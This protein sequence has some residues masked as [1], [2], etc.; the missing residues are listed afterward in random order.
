MND[1]EI[2]AISDRL[3]KKVSLLRGS[4]Y[5]Y[6]YENKGREIIQQFSKKGIHRPRHATFLLR[7]Q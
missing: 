5:Y 6:F 4:D 3:R 1:E 2:D 7:A